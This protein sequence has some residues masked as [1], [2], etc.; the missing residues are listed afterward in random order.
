MSR[1][2]SLRDAQAL[3]P[4]DLPDGAYFSMLHE[5]AGA[6]YGECWDELETGVIKATK[7]SCPICKKRVKGL[8]DHQLDAHGSHEPR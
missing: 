6:E 8:A 2:M 4:D 1:K 5:V 7:V 3:V